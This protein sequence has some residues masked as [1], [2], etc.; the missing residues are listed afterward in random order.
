MLK[1]LY[2]LL[3]SFGKIGFISLGG[4][5][6]MLKLIEFEA[7]NSQHWVS[8]AEFVQ[9]VGTS[10]FFPG[11]TALK[12]SAL[13]G[14]KTAGFWGMLT[15]LLALNLPGLILA[16]IGYQWMTS[17]NTPVMQ[18]VMVAVQ[19]GALALLAAATFSIGQ[20]VIGIYFSWPMAIS[21]L[22]FFIALTFF[23]LSPFWGLVAYIG[24]GYF[25]VK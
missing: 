22:V 3:I 6:A 13:I 25:L 9:M 10:V 23:N 8:N 21:L 24:I 1:T 16:L 2:A 17:H 5:N 12:L 20:G 18:K 7:I 15:A 11:L 4:G 19:Y 14:Y